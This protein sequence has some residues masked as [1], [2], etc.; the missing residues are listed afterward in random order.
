[1][2]QILMGNEAIALGLIHADV[3]VVSGYPGTPSS[4]I[5]TNYQKLKDKLNLTAYAEWATNEKVGYEVAY[6]NAMSGKNSCATMKQ[7]GLN[8]ASDALMSSAYIGN[9]GAMLLISADDPGFYSSQTEQDSRTFAKFARIPVLDPAS[10]QEAYDFVKL[11]VEISRKFESP[12][13]LRP[14]MRVGH[15]RG[16]CEVEENHEFNPPKANFIKNT[17]RWAGVPPGPRSVQGGELLNKVEQIRDYNLQTFISPKIA[18]L[19]GAKT[20]CISS[21]VASTYVREAIEENKLDAEVLK[22]DMPYPLP[23]HKLNELCKSYEQVI[24]FEEPY[25]CIEEQLNAPNLLGKFSGHV[26]QIHEF[27]KEKVIESFKK[28]RLFNDS[29]PYQASKFNAHSIASRPPTLCPGCPHRDVFYAMTR[30]FRSKNSIYVSDIGC[31]TLGLNQNA[32]DSFLCMGASVSMA[33]GFSLAHPEKTVISTIGDST[34]LHSGVT[35]LINA[36]YQK[37]KFIL[38]IMDNSIA[39]MTGRQTTP[40][41]SNPENIDIKRIVEG[42]GITCHEYVYKPDMNKTLDF[43]KELKE[44]YKTSDM[45]IVAVIREF[46]VLDKERSNKLLPHK[47]VSVDSDKCV[48]CDTCISKYKCPPMSYGENHKVEI[49]PFLCAGCAACI[50]GLCPTDAF[51]LADLGEEK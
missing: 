24:I 23:Y 27:S 41:R 43:M 30:T 13:M 7:V 11:G 25:P 33:S 36:I 29:N 21:G 47:L 8:V 16:I 18:E 50:D 2:K 14:V 19:K 49:D 31:Y 22:L 20:L 40:E 48:E 1:M 5:L 6:A 26:H 32:I 4:E 17:N 46:C 39:A 51:V 28:A 42:C 38:L 35:G 15:A 10:P 3:D 12:F 45:P 34:F 9:I 37:H 44:I